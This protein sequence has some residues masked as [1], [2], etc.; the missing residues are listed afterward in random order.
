[1]FNRL[2]EI[3]TLDQIDL[4]DKTVFVRS[5]LNTPIDLDN[6]ELIEL[7]RITDSI[8]TIN[9]LSSSKVVI[10][11]HQGRVGRYDYIT[12]KQHGLALENIL[13]RKVKFID[14]IYGPHAINEIKSMNKG[15]ILLLDNL[16][17]S[18]EENKEYTFETASKTQIIQKLHSLFDACILDGFPTAHRAH[19]TIVGFLEYMPIISGRLVTKELEAL[20]RLLTN[21]KS[22]YTA[23]LGGSKISDRL[24]AIDTLIANGKANKVL[25]T[26]V[27]ASVFLKATKNV[28]GSLNLDNEK[29]L[30]EKAYNLIKSYPTTFEI[31]IDVAIDNNG[32]KRVLSVSD[33]YNLNDIRDIGPK[34]IQ[35][36]SDIIKK[37]GTVYLSGPPGMFEKEQFKNGTEE[38]LRSLSSTLANTIVSG[39]H[40]TA[41]L[42]QYNIKDWIDHVSTS[43][44]ALIQYLAGK[45]LPLINTLVESCKRYKNDEY[46]N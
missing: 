35:A 26:G 25:V 13:N 7:N 6:K 27:L 24:E 33:V 28:N 11:S 23:V 19:P 41:A 42:E 30:T 39:G 40:L 37:S 31:P 17:F 22:P 34:T 29:K 20:S 45:E 15:D 9:D 12:M 18:A 3:L 14:D 32:I 44:G 43:G 46:R 5:D 38:L 1:M 2:N 4:S 36:Y 8:Q 21:A 16:R 10:G